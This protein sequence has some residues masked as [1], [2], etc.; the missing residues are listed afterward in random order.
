M[1]LYQT[2]TKLKKGDYAARKREGKAKGRKKK[3]ER[4]RSS[5][6]P[7][8]NKNR[9]DVRRELS[10]E[11]T[12]SFSTWLFFTN[13]LL[14]DFETLQLGLICGNSLQRINLVAHVRHLRVLQVPELLKQV[15]S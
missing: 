10:L 1:K 13:V 8:Q 7:K 12:F 11:Y 2:A 3:K 15:L 5:I 9:K 6:M 4:K 14:I